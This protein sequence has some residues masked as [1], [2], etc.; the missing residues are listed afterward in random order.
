[1]ILALLL[2]A[3][4]ILDGVLFNQAQSQIDANA[5][6]LM[7]SMLAVREY[8]SKEVNPIVD[9][10]N[11]K[12]STFLPEAVPS[13]S[14]TRVFSYLVNN[15]NYIIIYKRNMIMSSSSATD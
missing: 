10:I 9:P 4:Y 5:N 14:A 1:M 7:D 11:R 6:L 8:T 15:K 3:G 13:Y 2:G 12:E